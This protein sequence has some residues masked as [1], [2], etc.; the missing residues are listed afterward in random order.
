MAKLHFFSFKKKSATHKSTVDFIFEFLSK[1]KRMSSPLKRAYRNLA[2][3]LN[4][5]STHTGLPVD[6]DSFTEPVSEEFV[7][8]L[9]SNDLM[10]PTV[11]SIFSKLSASLNRAEKCGYPVVH[12]YK[13]IKIKKEDSCAVFLSIG[14]LEKT[15]RPGR[16][17][18]S[19]PRPL[20][21]RLLYRPPH[22][23]LP[24]SFRRRKFYRR[25]HPHKNPQNRR[26]RHHPHSPR[27]QRRF[28]AQQ[29]RHPPHTIPTV[30]FSNT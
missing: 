11:D 12:G 27:Y 20:P 26:T 28:E 25:L 14:E 17:L 2:K 1:T 7:E 22:L 4:N 18:Q 15:Q 23:R 8:F 30:I 24:Q 10:L 16:S 6:T 13:Y 19:M 21:G 5:F 29:Q 3:Y 9:K